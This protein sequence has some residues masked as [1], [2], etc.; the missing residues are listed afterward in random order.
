MTMTI[1]AMLAILHPIQ[2]PST[3][4]GWPAEAAIIEQVAMEY[5]LTEWQTRLLVTLRRC[6][7]GV[8]GNEWGIASSD[9]GHPAH[10]FAN[11][12]EKSV[13]LQAEFAAGSIAKRCQNSTA[14]ST[15]LKRW[16]P[17]GHIQEYRN[18]KNILA[19]SE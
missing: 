5:G 3:A 11:D 1:A 19:A 18:V 10:R 17:S 13:R 16:N 6:E 9:P 14:L 7:G 15:F 8:P 12:P 2:N 4:I